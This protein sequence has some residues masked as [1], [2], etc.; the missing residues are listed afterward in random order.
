MPSQSTTPMVRI[1]M[2][3][4]YR[5]STS[6]PLAASY[7]AGQAGRMVEISD[8]AALVVI[9]VQ[10]GFE[11]PYWG[12]RD[13][14]AAEENIATLVRAWRSAGRPIVLGRHDS[15]SPG[16]PLTTGTAGNALKDVLVDAL[17]D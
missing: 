7:G 14:P 11:D 15:V 9:D 4:K 1:L 10:K 16:S 12:R 17:G 13:N 8:N 3:E 5:I 6:M 2:A